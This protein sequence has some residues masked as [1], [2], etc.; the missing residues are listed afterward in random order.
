DVEPA[1]RRSIYRQRMLER[2]LMSVAP[3]LDR[4]RTT[5]FIHGQ[6]ECLE[7]QAVA[8]DSRLTVEP[9]ARRVDQNRDQMLL[10]SKT[11]LL[12]KCRFDAPTDQQSA[13]RLL[14]RD[15]HSRVC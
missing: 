8:R 14:P 12:S 11:K 15:V 4:C 9:H 3:T 5:R 7:E 10:H 2:Y 13:Q 6:R 1:P